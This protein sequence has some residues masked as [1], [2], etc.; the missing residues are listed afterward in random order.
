[1][2]QMAIG[3]TPIKKPTNTYESYI[4]EKQHIPNRFPTT[5]SPRERAPIE[6]VHTNICGP[7]HAQ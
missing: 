2:K 3:I 6:L 4:L 1:M 7:M 5:V